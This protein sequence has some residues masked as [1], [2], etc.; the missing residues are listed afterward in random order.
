[1]TLENVWNYDVKTGTAEM[2]KVEMDLPVFIPPVLFKSI[3]QEKLKQVL[4]DKGIIDN[5]GDVE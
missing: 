1:M 5:F 2:K 3:N 4:K